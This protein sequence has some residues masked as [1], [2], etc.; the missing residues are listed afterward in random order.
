MVSSP[1]QDGKVFDG[2]PF[3]YLVFYCAINEHGLFRFGSGINDPGYFAICA[4]S[5]EALGVFLLCLIH[6]CIGEREYGLCGSI[7]LFQL[8]HFG[9]W[10]QGR[11][12]KHVFVVGSAERIYGLGVITYHHNIA[13]FKGEPFYNVSLYR[14]GIL[15]FVNHYVAILLA[16]V[17]T[18]I[19]VLCQELSKK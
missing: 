18:D 7:I 3:V 1:K 14:V 16:E 5:K 9:L 15:I 8:D 13:V 19:L 2:S 11:K 17:L 6:Q 12:F 10:K 4:F